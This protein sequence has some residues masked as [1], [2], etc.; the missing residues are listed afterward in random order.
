VKYVWWILG[1]VVV[2][3]VLVMVWVIGTLPTAANQVTLNVLNNVAFDPTNPD[4]VSG[5]KW[6]WSWLLLPSAGAIHQAAGST[7]FPAEI[8]NLP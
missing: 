7:W 1:G 6:P 3:L 4:Q 8:Q 2:A 5:V